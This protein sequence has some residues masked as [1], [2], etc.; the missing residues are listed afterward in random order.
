MLKS[1][2]FHKANAEEQETFVK[3]SL[4][5]TSAEGKALIAKIASVAA[6]KHESYHDRMA[7]MKKLLDSETDNLKAKPLVKPTVNV[8][9]KHAGVKAAHRGRVQKAEDDAKA[10]AD[11][12]KLIHETQS[13]VSGGHKLEMSAKDK[14]IKAESE[15]S[16]ADPKTMDKW[17]KEQAKSTAQK[18]HALK[19]AADAKIASNKAA[20]DAAAAQSA[21]PPAAGTSYEKL[22]EWAEAHG[23]PKKLADNPADK[24]KVHDIIARMKADAEVA[25][26]KAQFKHDD[27]VV[28]GVVHG[29]DPGAAGI[30]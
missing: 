1:Q 17:M 13:K 11:G 6:D 18:K 3:H 8:Q 7:A 25:K 5:S 29:A 12:E 23:L 16:S 15:K 27:A 24:Q 21:D 19:K 4:K 9:P 14:A 10:I 22:V 30:I 28:G 26:I 2:H 20:K